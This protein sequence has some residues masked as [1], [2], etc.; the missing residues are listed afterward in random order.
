MHDS[1]K[2]LVTTFVQFQFFLNRPIEFLIRYNC[3]FAYV[4]TILT[5]LRGRKQKLFSSERL[6]RFQVS[7]NSSQILIESI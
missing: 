2:P 6:S 5:I 3:S 4:D 1:S 7:E